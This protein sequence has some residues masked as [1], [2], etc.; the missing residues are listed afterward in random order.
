MGHSPKLEERFWKKGFG[1]LIII[2]EN[3]VGAR[4]LSSVDYGDGGRNNRR[5]TAQMN[6]DGEV[7]GHTKVVA[8]MAGKAESS[9]FRLSS[10]STEIVIGS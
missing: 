1:L 4:K 8:G 7:G 5:E 2:H 3:R 10:G 9:G 6:G